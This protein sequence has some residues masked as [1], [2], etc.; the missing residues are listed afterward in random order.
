[1]NDSIR[2]F[3]LAVSD[4]A[5]ADLHARLVRT[6][7]PDEVNDSAWSYG[8]GID[9]LK[10]LTR[11]WRKQFDWR[12]AESRINALPQFVTAIDGLDLHFVHFRSRHADATPLLIAHGWPGSV[13]EFMELIPRLTDPE[14]FGGTARDAFHVVAPSLQGYGSSPPASAPGMSPL[15]IAKR[16]AALMSRLGYTRYLAQGGDWGS[17]IAHHTAVIDQQHCVGLHLNLL[18]PMP[19]KDVADPMALVQE[20][21]K[22]WLGAVGAHVQQGT[23]YIQIQRTRSQTLSYALTDSPTGWCAWV[24]EKFHAW[25]DCERDGRRDPRNAV[26]WDAMLTN[27]SL[28]W[29]T[30]TIASSI[31]LYREEALAEGRGNEK[32]GRVTVPTGVA[33][34]PAEIYLCPRAWAERRYPIVHWYEAPRGG[35]FAAMEQPELFAADLRRFKAALNL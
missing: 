22:A 29:Y 21:E 18:V 14:R 1:M 11:Y 10:E 6:R 30:E 7:W 9:Y 8:V 26:S 19:P 23:G 27:I 5:I 3:R 31:R 12:A 24:T 34:Y 35:H 16:H 20:H 32:L 4:E 28:Y 2:P 25:S 13:V 15:A 33:V 17:L